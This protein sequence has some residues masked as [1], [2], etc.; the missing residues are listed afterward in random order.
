VQF[1][2][3]YFLVKFY[4]RHFGP[5]IL[6]TQVIFVI[7]CVLCPAQCHQNCVCVKLINLFKKDYFIV[8]LRHIFWYIL[9]NIST[10]YNKQF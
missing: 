9:H 1:V 2:Q 5:K 7:L 8:D 6:W 4:R 10:A 3:V